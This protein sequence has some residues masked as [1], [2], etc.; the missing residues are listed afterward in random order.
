[1]TAAEKAH[2][3]LQDEAARQIDIIKNA[4]K[5]AIELLATERAEALKVSS[6]SGVNDHDLLIELKTLIGRIG[7]DI[8]E[9][10]TVI[11]LK[12]DQKELDE[13]SNNV[14]TDREKRMRHLENTTAAIWVAISIYTAINLSMIALL[15][16][17]ISK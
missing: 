15:I 7:K 12:A 2:K 13:L 8:T 11:E 9:F 14:Y 4:S 1:M 17:H 16:S 10:K 3:G 6:V 5:S